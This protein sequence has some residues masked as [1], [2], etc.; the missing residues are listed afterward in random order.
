MTYFKSKLDYDA[1]SSI[2]NENAQVNHFNGPVFCSYN[3]S[4][5]CGVLIAYLGK[6]SFLFN[7]QKRDKAGKTLILDVTLDQYILKK[8]HNANAETEQVKTLEQ[9]Q[10]LLKIV[11]INQNKRIIF[12]CGFNIFFNSKLEAK[13]GKPLLKR[14]SIAR[15]V[16]I[17]GSLDISHI[18]RIRNVKVLHLDK[19]IPLDLQNVD[20]IRFSHVTAFKNLSITP[21]ILLA[22]STAHSPVQ[23]PLLN[24]KSDKSDQGFWK[25]NKFLI[26]VA[27]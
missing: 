11:D 8:L 23:I 4:N 21:G 9:L 3:A 18:Q 15:L 26:Y 22:L 7:K 2:K 1:H 27:V 6:K 14:K 25:F 12:A 20:Q 13:G 10:S 17:K 19:T 24:H 5:S 16:E